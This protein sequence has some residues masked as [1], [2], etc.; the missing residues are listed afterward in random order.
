MCTTHL[1]TQSH[2]PTPRPTYTS[3]IRTQSH[4]HPPTHTPTQDLHTHWSLVMHHVQGLTVRSHTLDCGK[5]AVPGSM[6]KRPGP[7][8]VLCSASVPPFPSP[9]SLSLSHSVIEQCLIKVRH[10]QQEEARCRWVR[11]GVEYG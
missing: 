10:T 2:P 11:K 5:G 3:G 7:S 4:P 9:F 8:S 6:W 1:R